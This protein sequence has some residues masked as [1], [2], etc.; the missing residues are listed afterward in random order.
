[1]SE[2]R[3]RIEIA[4]MHTMNRD[5]GKVS[6]LKMTMIY[7]IEQDEKPVMIWKQNGYAVDEAVEY[8]AGRGLCA[9]AD[10]RVSFQI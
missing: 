1:M 2:T 3:Y 5:P 8:L 6:P 9:Y 4:R 10:S 7:E